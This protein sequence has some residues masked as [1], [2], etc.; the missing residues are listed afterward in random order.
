MLNSAM[1]MPFLSSSSSPLP[2]HPL[3]LLS[4]VLGIELRALCILSK[5]SATGYISSWAKD[6]SLSDFTLTCPHIRR[7]AIYRPTSPF[8]SVCL[9]V[10]EDR[11]STRSLGQILSSFSCSTCRYQRH[12]SVELRAVY[13]MRSYS[14]TQ[15]Q[16]PENWNFIA[17][18]GSLFPARPTPHPRR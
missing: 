10:G 11:A 8:T 12:L 9:S 17:R 4:A 5:D 15:P 13:S 1:G 14:S 6:G 16:L 2:P 3:L 7:Q 18:E